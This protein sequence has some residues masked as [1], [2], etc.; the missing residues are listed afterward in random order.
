MKHYT[1]TV[2]AFVLL[3]TSVAAWA[4][5]ATLATKR[6]RLE[7]FPASLILSQGS[8]N[9]IAQ[10]K[11][12][13]LW[14]GTWSGLIRYNGYSSTLFQAENL[15]GKLKSNKI[16]CIYE[17]RKGRLWIGTHTGGLF[18]YKKEREEFVQFL[19]NPADPNSIPNNNVRTIGE[20]AQGN[21]WIG[22]DHGLCVKHPDSVA[23][24]SYQHD[25]NNPQSI[26]SD[27]VSDIFLASTGKLWIGT[28]NGI[29]ELKQGS[30]RVGR[31]F[32]R[33]TYNDDLPSY[34]AHNYV[35]RITEFVHG[36][37]ATIWYT[38]T[39]G[40]KRIR[41][42][43]VENV[44]VDGPPPSNCLLTTRFTENDDNPYILIGSEEGL[45]FF[46]PITATFKRFLS[47]EDKELN[48][49]HNGITAMFFDRGGVLWI[50]TRKGL[51]KF[52]TY[53]NDF[54]GF[55]TSEFDASNTI[56]T[57]ILSS[58]DQGYWIST[59]GGGLYKFKEG[60][61]THYDFAKHARNDFVQ[62]IQAL[63]MDSKN[64]IW[65]ATAGSGIY[66][67]N[68]RDVIPSSRVISKFIHY[69]DRTTPKISDNYVMSFTEDK[70]GNLWV[71]SWSKGLNKVMPNS[72]EG[73]DN[74]LLRKP[75]VA[76]HVDHRGMLWV[77]TR[78]N[79]LYRL[80][81]QGS[82]LGKVQHFEFNDKQNSIS[83]NFI[84]TIYEDKRGRVLVG[85]ES[86]LNIFNTASNTF[87]RTVMPAHASDVVVSLLEDDD[88]KLWVANWDGLMV[89]SSDTS[90]YVKLYDKHDNIK[91]GFFYNNVC[92]K[93]S[94]GRL[95]FGGSE[96]FNIIDPG[97]VTQSPIKPDVHFENFQIAN[98]RINAGE[99]YDGRIILEKPINETRVID[100]NH[101]EN[102][103]SFEFVSSDYAA[104]GKVNYAFM[105]AGFDADW[106]YTSAA[107]R[108]ANYTNLNPGDYT[109][110]VRV[111][112]TDGVWSNSYKT[113]SI[114]I[115][116]PWWRTAWAKLIYAMVII[117]VLLL[118]RK[119]IV[120]RTNVLHNL[121]L[122]KLQRE[123]VE[124]LNKVKLQFFTNIS[125]EF[126]TPLTLIIGPVQTML[127]EADKQSR[128][129]HQ[130]EI[131]ND[132]SQ[133]L[134]RLVNQLL[135]FRK[136]ETENTKLTIVEGNIMQ[137]LYDIHQSF[138]PLA[139]K[140]NI[141]FEVQSTVKDPLLWF[142]RDMCEKI[143]FNLVSN[144]FKHTAPGGRISIDVQEDQTDI[145]ISVWDNGSG[146]KKKHLD[147]LFQTF[148]S[149][150]E[151]RAHASSGIGLALVKSLVDLH[152]GRVDVISEEN[153]FSK[154]TVRFKKGN[155]HF[156]NEEIQ[157]VHSSLT[158]TGSKERGLALNGL[159]PSGVK[160]D[161]LEDD[162]KQ[163]KL[164]IIED[165]SDV[166]EYIKSIFEYDFSIIQAMNGE[167]G[168]VKAKEI[169][170]DIIIA[171]IMMPGISGIAVCRELKA[172]IKTSHIPV[173][174]LTARGSME[175]K[176]EGLE[177]GADEYVT[178][179]FSPK[180][181]QLRVKN[182]IHLRKTL[183]AFLHANE[184]LSLEPRRIILNSP[185][186]L[187]L[188]MALEVVERNIDNA[189]Y[190]VEH[191]GRD[192]GMS[193]TQLYR[194][195]KAL[196]G[197]TVNDFIKNIRLKRAAQLLEHQHLTIAEV[198]YKVGFTDLQHFRA[199]FKK[200][201]GVTPSQ[202]AQRVIEEND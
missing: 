169:I 133:R 43:K 140:M 69:D 51:N 151:D 190:T 199:C 170:P 163:T 101:R 15:P 174:L 75:L 12:G 121:K 33:Y 184:T 198:T 148:F 50:G 60:K 26:S 90:R 135:D 19:N 28:G 176:V 126:R 72:I 8:I 57:G 132:N 141:V 76:M 117:G 22:T 30:G 80:D 38:S 154:F 59:L 16:S 20:D 138:G 193:Y 194:K 63:F 123:N 175:F 128:F 178:K 62:Y 79:G 156:S 49:S 48:L 147:S 182:L 9:C 56:I 58:H 179:P 162:S 34:D 142:D 6:I 172:N 14:I 93:D 118:L 196:T 185:D 84:N 91:G 164:L 97:K 61:F 70:A 168:L 122:E 47:K 52:D 44:P 195:V 88:G 23:F 160:P 94:Q 197:Q 120:F 134:L 177:S 143:F 65:V 66:R 110:K 36:D 166:S 114:H 73:W 46:D 98:Q 95:L 18:Q 82:S 129:H 21:L 29:C 27:V 187:F 192:V 55:L 32:R 92:L 53:A 139:E 99:K 89:L 157:S 24:Y 112:N 25:P 109:F 137:L 153:A 158:E 152:H 180:V 191:M 119:F 35:F 107:R 161:V 155:D 124:K 183:Q 189:N 165:N 96:G 85:T 105:L 7:Q 115:D 45:Y 136:V 102:S 146:I 171:D 81:P 87:S 42:G 116:Q 83:N 4:Q 39:K 130:L 159:G 13:F 188:K 67:F 74:D 186:E 167:D 144:S 68:E 71:G 86:G 37:D 3:L 173:I 202:Y 11:E 40:L 127:E 125:H 10:D 17:D 64:N 31:S 181:L 200:L 113:I 145:V 150:D 131:V 54:D 111:S 104:P 5:P 41:S 149:F 108:Y 2:W 106:H 103:I 201:F 100:L 78:G 1:R 77:G